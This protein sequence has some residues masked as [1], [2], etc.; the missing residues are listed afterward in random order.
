[1][2]PSRATWGCQGLSVRYGAKVALEDVTFEAP[3]G[4]VAA[5]VGGDGAG[6]TSDAY[7][8]AAGAAPT[9]N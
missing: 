7:A 2:S 8:A 4:T 5:V 1:M 6:K 9:T 3:A